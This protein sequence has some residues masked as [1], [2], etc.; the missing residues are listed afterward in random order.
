MGEV[1]IRLFNRRLKQGADRRGASYQRIRVLNVELLLDF[2]FHVEGPRVAVPFCAANSR[3]L[4]P[5]DSCER[6][7]LPHLRDVAQIPRLQQ[8]IC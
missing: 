5:N 7:D 8:Q 3:R 1:T 2:V 6:K 4:E